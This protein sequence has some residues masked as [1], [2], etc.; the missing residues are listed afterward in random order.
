[1]PASCSWPRA[2]TCGWTSCRARTAARSEA[3]PHPRRGARPACASRLHGAVADRPVG[4]QPRVAARSSRSA[5][6]PRRSHR[7]TR[8]WT[9]GSPRSSAAR[10]PAR[11]CATGLGARH[12]PR[13]GHGAEPHGHRLALGRRAPRLVH[14]A[15]DRPFPAYTFDGPDLSP[16]G[17]VGIYL[18]DHY[19]DNSD[20]A[21]V[22]RRQ[23]RWSGRSAT[24]TTATTAP[25]PVERH[26]AARLPQAGDAR[27]GHPDDP[28]GR[29]AVPDHPL[30]CGDD[31]REA[32][33]PALW[34]P[35]PGQRRGHPV[36]RR[37]RA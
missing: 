4:A 29:A 18:E 9:T 10:R 23:D 13:L 15:P 20:A 24:S 1:M 14:R 32:A 3:G 6:T 17:R 21:V 16:D 7:R 8:S 11:T 33:H 12:P 34:Y 36:A 5:A 25:L 19:F 28:G 30:R 31:A 2:R 35:L 27:G 37:V 26:G 22:F